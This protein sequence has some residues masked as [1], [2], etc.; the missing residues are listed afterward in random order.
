VSPRGDH[1]FRLAVDRAPSRIYKSGEAAT[2][3][4]GALGPPMQPTDTLKTLH[5]ISAQPG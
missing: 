3:F 2:V 5:L 1:D 4:A